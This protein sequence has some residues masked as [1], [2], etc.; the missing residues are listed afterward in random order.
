RRMAAVA[1]DG[2]RSRR[3][4]C[5]RGGG[6]EGA[7]A[8]PRAVA[9]DPVDGGGAAAVVVGGAAEGKP[10]RPPRLPRERGRRLR[11]RLAAVA[12]RRSAGNGGSYGPARDP[13][14]ALRKGARG[15]RARLCRRRAAGARLGRGAPSGPSR[16]A[17]APRSPG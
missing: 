17:P 12:G 8:P 6:G 16:L 5:P 1:R 10:G 4:L 14:A 13:H 2:G 3:V 7:A 9:G 15:P 11:P